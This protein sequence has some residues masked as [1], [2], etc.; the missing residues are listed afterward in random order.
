MKMAESIQLTAIS[1]GMP[2]DKAIVRLNYT[3]KH[4][5]MMIVIFING[6]CFVLFSR[7]VVLSSQ[8]LFSSNLS[9][10]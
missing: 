9:F 4:L 5:K 1:M 2:C 3:Y 8:F 6:Y 10:S 7:L